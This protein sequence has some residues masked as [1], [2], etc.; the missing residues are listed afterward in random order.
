MTLIHIRATTTETAPCYAL[1]D[2][3]ALLAAMERGDHEAVLAIT[4]SAKPKLVPI[5]QLRDVTPPPPKTMAEAAAAYWAKR[6][7]GAPKVRATDPS[8]TIPIVLEV[9]R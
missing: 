4:T 3:E 5:A 1:E 9:P 2:W 8:G 7:K 6:G